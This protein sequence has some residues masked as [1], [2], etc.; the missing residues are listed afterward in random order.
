MTAPTNHDDMFEH[1]SAI[2]AEIDAIT[3]KFDSRVLAAVLL[4]RSVVLYNALWK[5][6][7]LSDKQVADCFE[8]A[9]ELLTDES[10]PAPV[11]QDKRANVH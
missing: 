10:L 8:V 6:G 3:Q 7:I 2:H 5:A 1:A 4:N 9:V 11:V